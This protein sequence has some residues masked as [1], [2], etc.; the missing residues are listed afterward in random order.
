[1][2]DGTIDFAPGDVRLVPELYEIRDIEETNPSNRI[3]GFISSFLLNQLR[4]IRDDVLVAKKALFHGRK[5][6]VFRPFN[7]GMTET[8]VNL[9]HPGM[10]PMT[11]IDG[12]LRTNVRFRIPVIEV[13]HDSHK[14]DKDPQPAQPFYCF[15]SF[16]YVLLDHLKGFRHITRANIQSAGR[17]SNLPSLTHQSEF[18]TRMKVFGKMQTQ[19][20]GIY[21]PNFHIRHPKSSP[22][23]LPKERIPNGKHRESLKEEEDAQP[24]DSKEAGCDQ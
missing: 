15:R 22:Q 18:S 2:A 24:H 1:M 5:S 9:L 12:L 16:S 10:H 7:I 20:F 14:R 6:G 11:E 21:S 3:F 13:E 23:T 17:S 8:A 19:P 4:V